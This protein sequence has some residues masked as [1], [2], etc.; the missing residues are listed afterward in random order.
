MVVERLGDRALILKFSDEINQSAHL[1]VMMTDKLLFDSKIEGIIEWIP[2]YSSIT[3]VYNPE[4]IKYECLIEKLRHFDESNVDFIDDGKTVE[5]PVLYGGE[6]GPDIEFVAKTNNLS[7][8][9]VVSIHSS[10]DY[11]V[12]MIGFMPGF[13]YLYGLPSS[14][15]TPRLKSPRKFVPSGSVGIAGSQ[16]GIYPIDS[17]GG[18]QII[19]RTPLK[20]FDVK[21]DPPTLFDVGDR[22]K[23]IP[24]D[25]AGY[26]KMCR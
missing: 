1:S 5:I 14:I 2:S 24:T 10:A 23:F 25:K 20:I 17:P 15:N 11:E 16:T 6:F 12:W 19:G 4:I 26:E 8:E 9:D 7:V 18:W 21:K 3:L 13:P 22:I